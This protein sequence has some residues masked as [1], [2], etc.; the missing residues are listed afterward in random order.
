[1]GYSE[2]Y[3]GEELEKPREGLDVIEKVFEPLDIYLHGITSNPMILDIAKK[4]IVGGSDEFM[5]DDESDIE[6]TEIAVAIPIPDSKSIDILHGNGHPL[7]DVKVSFAYQSGEGE[8]IRTTTF[9]SAYTVSD[10]MVRADELDEKALAD[11]DGDLYKF[12]QDKG[13]GTPMVRKVRRTEEETA[14]PPV[15]APVENPQPVAKQT[16][17]KIS[18]VV[19]DFLG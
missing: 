5:N 16:S 18:S 6:L 14:T 12:F 19:E 10:K 3:R 13:K 8:G 1:M 9:R 4:A 2:L 15:A 11:G 7:D 17:L